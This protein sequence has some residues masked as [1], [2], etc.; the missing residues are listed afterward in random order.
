MNC[1][2]TEARQL[3]ARERANLL[4]NEM[5]ATRRP[6]N[7]QP[8]SSALRTLAAI[9]RRAARRGPKFTPASLP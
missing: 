1:Y 7:P 8:T 9:A 5:R 2:E 4:A 3:F 6:A